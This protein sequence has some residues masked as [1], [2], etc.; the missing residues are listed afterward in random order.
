MKVDELI[1]DVLL[2]MGENPKE[3]L[4]EG[5]A[6]GGCTLRE[7]IRQEVEEAAAE[8]VV[9]TPRMQLTG[10]RLLPDEGLRIDD[11]GRGVLP[12]PDDFLL[13]YDVRMTSWERRATEVHSH[14]DWKRRLQDDGRP[15]LRG[16][17][18][19]P[20]VFFCLNEEGKLSPELFS[21]L[22][23]RRRGR[24]MVYARPENQRRRG[25][26][27]PTGGISEVHQCVGYIVVNRCM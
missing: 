6:E 22:A 8:A 12:L 2:L 14:D 24:R 3:C 27:D 9:S 21:C 25:D 1:D 23:H 20:L 4:W 19:L 10:W 15:G 11:D 18:R 13:L 5:E 26:R 16:T 7:R 17:P